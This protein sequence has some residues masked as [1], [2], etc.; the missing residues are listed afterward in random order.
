MTR[1]HGEPAFFYKKIF[2]KKMKKSVDKP[3]KVCYHIITEREGKPL[4][5][6]KGKAMFEVWE[7]WD[8]GYRSA[9][10]VAFETEEE[11]VEYIESHGGW[12][13]GFGESGY[14]LRIDGE[15]YRE[16]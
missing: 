5:T 15:F 14:E 11:A 3:E 16:C 2:S 13:D 8:G 9:M 10:E 1:T 7:W 4:K 12:D 6:R